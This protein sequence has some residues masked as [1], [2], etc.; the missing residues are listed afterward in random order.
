MLN[1]LW[2]GKNF[3]ELSLISFALQR[4]LAKRIT[5]TFDQKLR[6]FFIVLVSKDI[7]RRFKT[8]SYKEIFGVNLLYAK[9]L[10][11]LLARKSHVTTLLPSDWFEFME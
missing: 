11:L 2:L 1:N 6:Q 4:V 10:A 3:L 9:I 5:I 7:I 8:R